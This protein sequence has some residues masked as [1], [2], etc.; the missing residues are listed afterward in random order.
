[1]MKQWKTL[2][3]TQ[4]S[5]FATTAQAQILGAD[6]ALHVAKH[7]T[8]QDYHAFINASTTPLDTCTEYFFA[9]PFASSAWLI[10]HLQQSKDPY[11]H[12]NAAL[13]ILGVMG[14]LSEE[15]CDPY[16]ILAHINFANMPQEENLGVF[17]ALVY[18]GAFEIIRDNWG[19]YEKAIHEDVE[20][21]VI[22]SA[23]WGLDIRTRVDW[24]P[25]TSAQTHAY[26]TACCRGGLLERVKEL[27]VGANEQRLVLESFELSLYNPYASEVREYL[28]EAYPN[29]KWHQYEL[30]LHGIEKIAPPL[31]KKVLDH[32]QQHSTRFQDVACALICGNLRTPRQP[33]FDILYPYITAGINKIMLVA[34]ESR[35][36]SVLK[37]LL[38]RPGSEKIFKNVLVFAEPHNHAWALEVHAE[39]QNKKLA[40]S[41]GLKKTGHSSAPRKM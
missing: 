40:K 6:F 2:R 14:N 33:L 5:D 34:I 37:K 25:V 32:F 28:W 9:S 27:N 20:E 7:G 22:F 15:K 16:E 4:L 8:Q 1:M 13:Y 31:Q 19:V 30:I 23:Q 3:G 36:K 18:A 38:Q 41:V 10:S 12:V 17:H 29:I 26:F 24:Q 35:K 39:V 11:A 21:N